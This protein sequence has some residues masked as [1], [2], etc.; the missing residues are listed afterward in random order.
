[1]IEVRRTLSLATLLAAALSGGCIGHTPLSARGIDAPVMFG[2]VR[3]LGAQPSKAPAASGSPARMVELEQVVI[4]PGFGGSPKQ[5]ENGKTN[6]KT[7]ALL[8]E[9]GRSRLHVDALRC[10]AFMSL[11]VRSS[12]CMAEGS[13]IVGE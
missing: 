3:V 6:A 13:L 12:W 9:M 7:I 11:F 2:P 4:V 1:M 8:R 10:K 5:L